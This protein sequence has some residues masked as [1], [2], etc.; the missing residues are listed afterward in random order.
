[1]KVQKRPKKEKYLKSEPG[2]WRHLVTLIL[3]FLSC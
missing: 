3:E 1:M 2:F